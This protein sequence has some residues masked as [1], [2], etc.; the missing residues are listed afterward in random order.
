MIRPRILFAGT[1][2]FAV[3]SLAALIDSGNAPLAVLTQPDR[4]AG[5]GRRISQSPVKTLALEYDIEVLQ[6]ESLRDAAVLAELTALAPDL[7]V[8]AAYGLILPQAALDIPGAGCPNVHAPLLPRGRGAAPVQAAILAGD[9]QTGVSLMAMTAG[10]DSGPVYAMESVDIEGEETAGELT[11]KLARLGGELL[12]ARLDD[13]LAGRLEPVVQDE[14]RV[15]NAP[16]IHAEDA[17]LDWTL[18]AETLARRVRAYDPAPGAWFLLDGE[19]IK[20]ARAEAYADGEAAPGT[21]VSAG[22]AGVVVS[23]GEGALAL[24]SL[25]RPGRRPVTAGEFTAQLD[26]AGRRL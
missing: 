23:C 4:P 19:R 15:T 12:Q 13:V 5:R 16:R 18:P 22:G 11:G 10:L 17:R 1:P 9:R 8:V 3:A 25:Q 24:R 26:L 6:P 2:D 14:T 7:I 21:V 20:C